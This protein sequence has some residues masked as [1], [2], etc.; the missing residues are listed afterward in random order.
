[1]VLKITHG[2]IVAAIWLFEAANNKLSEVAPGFSSIGPCSEATIPLHSNQKRQRPFLSNRRTANTSS[3]YFTEA[4]HDSGLD[5][6]THSK[7]S[8]KRR[9]KV[10]KETAVDSTALEQRIESLSAQMAELTAL[11][12]AQQSMSNEDEP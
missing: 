5:S 6:P 12:V 10:N 4:P 1:V 2:P 3:Q 7:P 8:V 9:S 11:I